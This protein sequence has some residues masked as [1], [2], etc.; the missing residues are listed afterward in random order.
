MKTKWQSALWA[1]AVAILT[2]VVPLVL[3]WP[4][5]ASAADDPWKTVNRHRDH[6]DHE[7]FFEKEFD[8]PQAVTRSCLSCHPQAASDVM[9][10]AHWTWERSTTIP[11][12]EEK[13]VR[14]G[15]KNLINN[16]C[17]GI[18]GNWVS[19]N[20]CHAGYGWKDQS[21]DF[22]QQDHVDCLICHDWTGSYVK[23]KYGMPEADVDLL[24][25]ARKV[26]YP[27]RENCGICHIYGG[28]GMGVKHGDLDQTLVNP[29]AEVDVHMG[30]GK[31]L[32]IDCHR[33][34]NHRISGVSFSVS[35]RHVNGVSCEDCH[36]A[37]PHRDRR[38]NRHL[39]AL[40]CQACHIPSFARR[41]PTKVEWDWQKAGD[42]S[43][44]DDL[45]HYLKIKG[46]FV[47]AQNVLPQYR[48]FNLSVDRYLLGDPVSGDE[49]T[50]L[51]P[52]RGDIRDPGSRIWPFKIHQATQPYDT[53]NRYLLV[54]VTS[55]ENGYWTQF[56]WPSALEMGAK[57][58]GLKFS[59]E[60]GFVRTDMF[61]PLSHM[62]TP[63]DMA[64]QC[65]D[66]HEHS[67]Q[68]KLRF[69]WKE[70]GYSGDPIH[71]GG[72]STIAEAKDSGEGQ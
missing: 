19:C 46:E 59:G 15:K 33:T 4:G 69:N 40:S 1:L 21:F 7:P 22:S 61:W 68:E 27:R 35:T 12:K 37:V 47:Y 5:G 38:I 20:S 36:A 62:V 55:G 24:L 64:L 45:H 60:Y 43:R 58:T 66:C 8:S 11:G 50:L 63:K 3:F 42:G 71:V 32:C 16:F 34:E 65:T 9:K 52:P 31:L 28:G 23:G 25:V 6:L 26:G 14:I 70:L 56:D 67:G 17:I 18:T 41:A 39:S 29:V 44:E 48:W 13:T 72:R 10:T 30:R 49:V 53:V 57:L 51:N 54:P 2:V